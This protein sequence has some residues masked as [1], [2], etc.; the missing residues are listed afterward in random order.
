MALLNK[1]NAL[2]LLAPV[3]M[4]TYVLARCN[5]ICLNIWETYDGTILYF[6]MHCQCEQGVETVRVGSNVTRFQ[7]VHMYTRRGDMYTCTPQH[8][9]HIIP[10]IAGGL[11]G[12]SPR[13]HN[14]ASFCAIK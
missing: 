12:R 13:S 7:T 1:C 3:C 11:L 10:V 9:L 8:T 14:G 4:V 6:E 2:F 5:A